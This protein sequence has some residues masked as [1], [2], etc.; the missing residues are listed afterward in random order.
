LLQESK[1]PNATGRIDLLGVPIGTAAIGLIMLAIVE[2]ET[3][4][5]TDPR[6]IAMFVAGLALIP[7]LLR[8]SRNHP[9]PLIELDL[10][11]IRS[12][13]SANLG[14]AMYSMAFTSG[15]LVNSILLQRLW[16]QP[17]RTVGL[18]L[19]L[20]PLLSA[21]VSPL[22]GRMADAVGHRWILTIGG[23]ILGI[24]YLLFFLLLDEDPHVFDV[25]VPISALVGLGV[26]TTI[27]TW[28]SAGISDVPMAKF[29]TAN[30]TLRTTQQVCYA[31]GISI[32]VTLLSTGAD[33]SASLSGYRWA[34]LF[35]A[36]MYFASAVVTAFTFPSGS[37]DDRIGNARR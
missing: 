36:A 24:G 32:V 9:E 2:S 3:W 8:R 7:V 12:F 18:A 17:I 33:G 26:G 25:Y 10:F 4:G 28:A 14:V 21:V 30:A 34:W 5:I 23:V 29:G 6:A 16:D 27:A 20:S 35:I 11:E 19:L 22:S 15:F 1:N 31:L 37:S 13:R